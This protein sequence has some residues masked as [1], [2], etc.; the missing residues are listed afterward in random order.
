VGDLG[1]DAGDVAVASVQGSMV[2]PGPD[3]HRPPF[4][5]TRR[6]RRLMGQHGMRTGKWNVH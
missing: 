6:L 1:G 5:T 3:G 4:D 2:Q